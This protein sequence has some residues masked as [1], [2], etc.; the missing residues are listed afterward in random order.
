MTS[1]PELIH[2]SFSKKPEN[3]IEITKRFG[4][5]QQ[6]LFKLLEI[7]KLIELF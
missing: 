3:L 5:A 4:E 2:W 6:D 1:L 7:L